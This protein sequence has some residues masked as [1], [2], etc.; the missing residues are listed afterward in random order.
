MRLSDQQHRLLE[1]IR[2]NPRA[3]FDI[4]FHAALF[5]KT[6][7]RKQRTIPPL[8]P[9]QRSSLSRSLRRLV[10]LGLVTRSPSGTYQY[11]GEN[12]GE[13]SG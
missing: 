1:T 4:D 5:G 6:W 9:S 7:P 12:T 11:R 2:T 10:S 3:S 8:T 13:A